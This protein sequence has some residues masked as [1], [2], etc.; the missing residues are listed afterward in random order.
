MRRCD[1]E[2]QWEE[3]RDAAKLPTIHGTAS[4][5]KEL[6]NPNVNSGELKYPLYL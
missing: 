5:N 2:I 4:Q 1:I 3:D 6:F